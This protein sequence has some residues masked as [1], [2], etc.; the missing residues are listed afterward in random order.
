[1]DFASDNTAGA[2]ERILDAILAA[3]GGPAS[4]YG[5]D[6]FTAGARAILS[7]TFEK[8]LVS[9]LVAT[10]T[11]SNALALGA[12]CPAFGA[13]FCHREAHVMEDECGAPE[14]FTAGAKLIGI[15]GG[16]GKIDPRDL[17]ATLAA[18]PRGPVKQVQPA[19]LSLSQ[20]TESGA[21]YT[22][23]EISELAAIAHDAG[24]QVHMDGARFAN[25]LVALHCKPAAMSWLAGVDVLS[26]GATKNGAL[27]CEAVIFFDA[28]KAAS[29]PFQRKRSGHL[30]SKGRFLGAQMIAYLEDG[31]WLGLAKTAN[32]QAARLEEGLRDAPGVRRVWPRQANELFV[33]LPRETD[34][35][36]K[37]AGAHYYEWSLRTLD[38]DV[39]PPAQNEIFVRLV[40]SFATLDEDIE[41]FVAVARAKR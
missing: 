31:H 16:A 14:M 21:L 41:R 8:E 17:A 35:A 26:F 39:T 18:F 9:F 37:A 5:E 30:L 10:G 34:A 15:P 3:N 27:A 4:A 12:L 19:V 36:L 25:A 11:A 2:S 6:P 24:L 33:I 28:A 22:C 13:V 40:T 32:A 29:L 7:E 38:P 23:A 20:P 1:M